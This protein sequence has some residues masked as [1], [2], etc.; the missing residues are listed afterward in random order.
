M[1]SFYILAFILTSTSITIAQQ[2][3]GPQLLDKAIQYHDPQGHWSTFNDTLNITMTMPESNARTSQIVINIPKEYFS[4]TAKKDTVTTQYTIIKDSCTIS[5]NGNKKLTN[6]Q[7]KSNNLSCDR[8]TLYKNYYTYLYGLPMKLKDKGTI[9][10]PEAKTVNFKSKTY[11]QLQV[12]YNA[13]VGKDVWYFYFNPKTYAIEMYQFYKTDN[14]GQVDTNTG[15]YIIL[16]DIKTVN[17]IKIPKIRTW[18]Y[19][20]DDKYLATDNLN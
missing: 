13:E 14:I 19:N 11:L 2:I 20:K 10:S 12:N 15:E 5:L 17:G 16:N 7:I 9:I 3:S 4:V 18:Y 1:K 8:A 6:K